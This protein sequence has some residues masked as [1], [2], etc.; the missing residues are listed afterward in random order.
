MKR[1]LVSGGLFLCFL[2]SFH[3]PWSMLQTCPIGGLAP[4]TNTNR[5]SREPSR[6]ATWFYG[7][8][9]IRPA[10]L[11]SPM[12]SAVK[13]CWRPFKATRWSIKSASANKS[14]ESKAM[15][16]KSSPNAARYFSI[17]R[18]SVAWSLKSE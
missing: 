18:P 9:P 7:L 15:V 8:I 12:S 3:F 14:V 1:S 13:S 6:K 10:R 4:K 11:S 5:S 16:S 2:A 17:C